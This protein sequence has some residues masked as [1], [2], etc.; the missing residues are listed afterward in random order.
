VFKDLRNL[1]SNIER[2]KRLR[3]ED[4]ISWTPKSLKEILNKELL[5]D[6]VI[7]V[8]N[9]EPYIHTK[10]D[11]I[12]EI[13]HPASGVV[14]ALEPVMK[15]CSGTW[16]AHG[17]GN[18]DKEFVDK[19][20]SIMV[21]PGKNQYKL[22]RVWLTP[23]EENGYY[24][25]FANE[26]LWPLCHIAHV[27]PM[28]KFSDW[29]H[30][31]KVNQKF[32]EAVI[33][34]AKTEDPV[35]LVQ[36]YHLAM[37]P[38]L[39][40]EKLPKA[41]IITFWHIPWPNPE[42]FGICPWREEILEGLLSSTIV[43]FHTQY[44]CNN[45]IDTVDRYLECRIDRSYSAIS[46]KG[47]VSLINSYPI[48]ID[49]P[50]IDTLTIMND[51]KSFIESLGL[52]YSDELKIGIGVDRMDYTKG[53]ME[54]F[55]SIERFFE[56]Y[57]KWLGKFTFLQIAAPTRSSIEDYKLFS[58]KVHNLEQKINHRFST[59]NWK[60]ILLL[61]EHHDKEKIDVFYY[62][63]D[64][65]FVSSL[66]DGM[67][68]VAKEYISMR[69]N[70][71]GVLILSQFAGA[72]MELPEAL[73]VNPYNIEQCADAVFAGLE[74]PLIEQK[75]RMKS[76]RSYVSEFNVYRWAGRMLVDSARIR[77]REKVIKTSI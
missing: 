62:H 14:T 26:G 2:E 39:I 23:E 17:S 12:V 76:M 16:I 8:S 15:A 32:A 7:I 58:E 28:F 55:L 59:K 48:S 30:Y 73:I 37:L 69:L 70:D 65:C 33:K 46:Y 51:K 21:P 20:D 57:P 40:K 44:H 4:K 35:V 61:N 75:A 1:I 9:R 52:S 50:V 72:A 71:T 45:F 47:K 77:R 60:P 22:H 27:R 31:N 68:L 5:G 64:L 29:E 11:G 63:G 54:R 24:Y 53:I 34:E 43:G 74:L 3:D 38:K 19:Y 56:K 18:A 49:F 6:E 66:H 36:D 42:S 41:T 67:N 13:Q 25:G 10:K